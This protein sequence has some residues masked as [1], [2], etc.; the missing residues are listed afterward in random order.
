MPMK[1]MMS[2]EKETKGT[3]AAMPEM[4]QPKYPYG[5]QI[6]LNDESIETLGMTVMPAVGATMTL[7]AKVKVTGVHINEVLKDED[8][9]PERRIELQIT[10]ME[11]GEGKKDIAKMM[12]PSMD[13]A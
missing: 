13:K 9:T 8:S 2:K 4:E 11:L 5:L 6:T 12:Y 3:E 10:D 7:T 1:S